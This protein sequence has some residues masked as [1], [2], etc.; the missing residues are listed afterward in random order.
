M[1]G[2][3]AFFIQRTYAI[4]SLAVPFIGSVSIAPWAY[5][6]FAAF[7][8]VAT[9]NGVNITDGLDGLA[10]GTRDLRFRRLP[11]HRAAQLRCRSR[12]WRSCARCSSAPL[13]GFLWFNVHPAQIFMGDSGALALGATLA[14]I[15]LITGQ[16]LLLP[17]IG[18]VF[19]LEAGSDIIQIFCFRLFRPARI[20]D[21]AAAP[22]LRARRLGRR[23][24][25]ACASGSS[26]SSPPCSASSSTSRRCS[27]RGRRRDGHGTDRS[28]VPEPRRHSRGKPVA[29]L[30][31]AR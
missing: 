9:T 14:V 26:A 15:A 11:D 18:I 28:G 4:D 20:P 21:R 19:V 24:D 29:V 27:E 3:I 22:P 23:E 1:A 12:T 31:L 10:G 6:A 17:L 8:I 30:G 2:V 5:I 16:I 7:A 13:L 25:H